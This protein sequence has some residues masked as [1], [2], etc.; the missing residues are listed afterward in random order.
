LHWLFYFDNLSRNK[1]RIFIDKYE[2][3]NPRL[4]QLRNEFL[5]KHRYYWYALK[6]LRYDLVL[7]TLSEKEEF[8]DKDYI[9]FL[10][11]KNSDLIKEIKQ[12]SPTVAQLEDFIFESTVQPQ[13][14]LPARQVVRLFF[15]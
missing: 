9:M 11:R 10:F 8:L 4:I 7:Q 3:R 5:I 1:K 2:G 14:K 15:C 6:K 13:M 12:K